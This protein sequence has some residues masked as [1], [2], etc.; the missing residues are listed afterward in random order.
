[1]SNL[2]PLQ[3]GKFSAGPVKIGDTYPSDMT[4]ADK[5]RAQRSVNKSV[6]LTST[7]L[8]RNWWN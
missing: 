5:D 8:H 6:P 2:N 1:M 3:F 7:K 4:M